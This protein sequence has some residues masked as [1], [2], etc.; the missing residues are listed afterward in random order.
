MAAA[1]EAAA[2]KRRAKI[3]A[4]ADKEQERAKK[5]R[6]GALL[7]QKLTAKYGNSNSNGSTKANSLIARQVGVGM[8]RSVWGGESESVR[9]AQERD[10][11]LF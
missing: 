7:L 11:F 6:L 9:S 2:A 5:A 3:Q 8:G 10:A 1:T 4:L